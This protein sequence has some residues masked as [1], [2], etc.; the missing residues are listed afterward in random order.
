MRGTKGG[1][2]THPE[3][4]R[5]GLSTW[6]A[7]RGPG[8]KSALILAPCFLAV[9][10]FVL[11]ID[12]RALGTYQDSMARFCQALYQRATTLE[13][14][15]AIDVTHPTTPGGYR[16]GARTEPLSCGEIRARGW[17]DSLVAKSPPSH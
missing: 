12:P 16:R 6:W 9:Y 11:R 5:G 15:A 2:P 4:P 17:I 7:A 14:A 1:L 8:A 3:P 13:Q 10:V